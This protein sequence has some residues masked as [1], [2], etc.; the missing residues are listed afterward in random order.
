MPGKRSKAKPPTSGGTTQRPHHA[1]HE[2]VRA[3]H[4][5]ETAE[6]YVEAIAAI[7]EQEGRCR[8]V[9]L[10]RRF[11]V[12]HVT[13]VR[14]TERLVREGLVR[15][16]PYRPLELTKQGRDLA[17]VSA[18]RHDVVYRFLRAIGVSASTASVDAEG[19]E[20]HVSPETL[21]RFRELAENAPTL[22]D[23][24]PG[25]RATETG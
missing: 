13:V 20:H 11:G 15:T 19:I 21:E 6:D 12:S 16:E 8:V 22:A 25:G 4:A 23:K 17:R 9:D 14:T 5:Q 10:A 1:R 24:E 3:A 7:I 18:E 2:G